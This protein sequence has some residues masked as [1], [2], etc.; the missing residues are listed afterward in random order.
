MVFMR[1]RGLGLAILFA[2]RLALCLLFDCFI[3]SPTKRLPITLLFISILATRRNCP[4]CAKFARRILPPSV[5]Q[6]LAQV[7]FAIAL[8]V[9]IVASISLLPFILSSIA[10]LVLALLSNR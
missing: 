3:L 9:V 4:F 10:S 6:A 8:S 5:V 1:K 2:L 7:R